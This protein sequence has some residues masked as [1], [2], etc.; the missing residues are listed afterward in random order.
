MIVFQ[1]TRLKKDDGSSF[2]LI[3]YGARLQE[4]SQWMTQNRLTVCAG[5]HQAQADP[6]Q[7]TS[8][9]LDYILNN[10]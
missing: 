8:Q 10:A 5:T 4:V 9:P 6:E 3:T 7:T 2:S 1:A